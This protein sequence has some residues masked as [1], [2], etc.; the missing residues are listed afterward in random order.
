MRR[1]LGLL[2]LGLMVIF[3]FGCGETKKETKYVEKELNPPKAPSGLI[4]TSVSSSQIDLSW[5]D[6][7]GNESRL[8]LWRKTGGE[9]WGLVSEL[10]A[11]TTSYSDTGLK[12]ETEYFYQ[13]RACNRD[14]CSKFSE[15]TSAITQPAPISPP[16]APSGLSA[17]A[18]S[19]SQ[20][21]LTWQ[22]NS[23]DEDGFKIE[24][25]DGTGFQE[26]A[27]IS[28]NQTSYL[29]ENLSP[30]TSYIY[31]V[32]AYNSAG[33]SGYS[34][35]AQATT[36]DLSASCQGYCGGQS[37]SGCYCDQICWDYGDCCSD[38]CE[39][40]GFCGPACVD[41]DGDGFYTNPRC[42][43]AGDCEDSDSTVYPGAPELCDGKDN[44][45]PGDSGYGR[46]DETCYWARTYGGEDDDIPIPYDREISIK[47]TADGNYIFSTGSKSFGTGNNEGWI[48]KVNQTGEIIWQQI[49]AGTTTEPIGKCSDIINTLDGG[50]IAICKNTFVKLDSS[51]IIEWEKTYW[52]D[53]GLFSINLTSDGGYIS[54]GFIDLASRDVRLIKLDANGNKVWEK[55]YGGSGF[56]DCVAGI[57]ELSNGDYIFTA[58]STSYGAGR[59][60]FWVVR[61]D[62]NGNM[63]WDKTFGGTGMEDPEAMIRTSDN[64]LIITGFTTSY[65]S[66]G[67][68]VW[69]LKLD[70]N[71]NLIWSKT[72]GGVGNE[73]AHWSGGLKEIPGEGYV[74]VGETNSYGDGDKDIY[75]LKIDPDGNLI[76]QKTYGGSFEDCARSVDL[77]P[78]GGLI[79]AG[80]TNSFGAGK[81]DVWILKLDSGGNCLG[82]GCP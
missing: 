16:E 32:K 61:I 47:T 59:D 80:Y 78:D 11:D 35:Q 12:A 6:N 53:S 33:E 40:C 20:V 27:T 43:T 36:F 34:N 77:T 31:Q 71:G 1:V 19:S 8:E 21:L 81:Y 25:D 67:V 3:L 2:A 38:I 52:E 4:A 49:L 10:P 64:Y 18:L 62:K 57:V 14:G 30:S 66:G 42:G 7:S 58:W 82:W 75:I 51:G 79:V 72:F 15:T 37:P 29:D 46:I 70:T 17:S 68:D 48:V 73:R 50:Y 23:D 28:A 26:I 24:R 60:D 65:G 41:A 69:V 5:V 63:V 54:A 56:E 55:A 9:I 22:H 76:W 44:Q 39:V 13:I 45:C 74:I